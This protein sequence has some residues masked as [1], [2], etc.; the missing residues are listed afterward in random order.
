MNLLHINNSIKKLNKAVNSELQKLTNWLNTNKISPYVSKTELILFKPKMKKLDFDLKVKPNG[1]RLYQPKSVKYLG[2]KISS[3]F[4]M[5]TSPGLIIY[6][7]VA[8]IRT[9]AFVE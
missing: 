7:V 5:K 8:I 6:N 1:K 3:I 9:L 2:I 4:L